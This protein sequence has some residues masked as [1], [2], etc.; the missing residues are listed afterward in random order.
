[1]YNIEFTYY[2]ILSIKLNIYLKAAKQ[3]L[4]THTSIAELVKERVVSEEFLET[5]E[6]EQEILSYVNTDR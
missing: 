2:T 3:S 4:G 1:M 6:I 5:L